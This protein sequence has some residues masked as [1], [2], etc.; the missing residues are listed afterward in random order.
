MNVIGFIKVGEKV[1]NL[2]TSFF[3][4]SPWFGFNTS[5]TLQAILNDEPPPAIYNTGYGTLY[6]NG[7][8]PVMGF[9]PNNTTHAH[10]DSIYIFI[11]LKNS[12]AL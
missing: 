2:S 11:G 9:G 6:S 5:P 1:G 4:S 8:G 7:K 12:V 10:R 3:G